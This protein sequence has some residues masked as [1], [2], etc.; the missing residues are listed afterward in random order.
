MIWRILEAVGCILIT[1][2][3]VGLVLAVV[4]WWFVH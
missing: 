1:G 4:I 2:A 3:A